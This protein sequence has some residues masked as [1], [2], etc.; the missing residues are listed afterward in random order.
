MR[1]LCLA[2]LCLAVSGPSAF[3]QDATP[4]AAPVA[5]TIT[6]LP[7]APVVGEATALTFDAPVDAVVITYRPNSAIP[8]VDTVRIGGFTSIKWTPTEAGVVRVAVPDG[9]SR[10]L[11]I[12][13]AELPLAGVFVLIMAGLILFGGASWAMT[14]LLSGDMPKTQP[15]LRPD[16]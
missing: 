5:T 16:T 1:A 15:E 4:D 14:K 3:A 13:F 8:V 10:N 9:P 11:S 7:E 6:V 12:R 2:L